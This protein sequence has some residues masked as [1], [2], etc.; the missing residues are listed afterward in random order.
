LGQHTYF[1]P[2][3]Y[4]L[5]VSVIH[6]GQWGGVLL[7]NQYTSV[8][9]KPVLLYPLLT[10]LGFLF[11]TVNPFFLFFLGNILSGII[12]LIVF[13]NQIKKLGFSPNISLIALLTICL[14]GGVGFLGGKNFNSADITSSLVTFYTTFE[15]MHE[16]IGVIFFTLALTSFFLFITHT[17]R[18]K[19]IVPTLIFLLGSIFI[20]P[21]TILPFFIITGVFILVNKKGRIDLFDCKVFAILFVPAIVEVFL[22]FEELASNSTFAGITAHIIISVIPLLLGY[23]ILIPIFLYQLF[24]LPRTPI[25]IFLSVWFITIFL[26]GI[27]PVGPGRVFLRGSFF[28]LTLVSIVTVIDLIKRFNLNK[29]LAWGF[30]IFFLIGTS[31]SIFFRQINPSTIN[32]AWVYMPANDFQVFNYLNSNT[33][34]SS[35]IVTLSLMSNQIPAFTKNSVFF[36]HPT[37]SRDFTF[38][39]QVTIAFF[40]GKLSKKDERNFLTYNNISYIVIGETEK[41]LRKQYPTTGDS[42]S[43]IIKSSQKVFQGK[44]ISLYKVN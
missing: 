44:N 16:A 7:A 3:D 33:I 40:L 21:Y 6:Y 41:N 38:N 43:T 22:L 11:K 15:K 4:N 13:F 27:L 20:Y 18:L 10:I 8:P 24:F 35:S 31:I 28:P 25:K 36:G 14:G 9:N 19:P 37:Q 30:F 12:L 32:N 5:Y 29:Y 39:R 2:W 26:L 42:F 17:T 23:G 1:D 34:P